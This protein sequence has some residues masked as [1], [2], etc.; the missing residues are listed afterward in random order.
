MPCEY[1]RLKQQGYKYPCCDDNDDNVLRKMSHAVQNHLI[2]KV[3][4][5]LKKEAGQ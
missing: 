5:A 3:S 4:T 2:Q 1:N